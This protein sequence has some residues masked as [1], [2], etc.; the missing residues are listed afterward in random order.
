MDSDDIPLGPAHRFPREAMNCTFEV[1]VVHADADYARQAADAAFD[2]LPEIEGQ[3]SRF[4][5]DSDT[6]NINRLSAGEWTTVGPATWECLCLAIEMHRRTGGA[7]DVTLGTGIDQLVLAEAEHAV[8]VRAGGITVD[9]GGIGKGYA[10]DRMLAL[11]ADWLDAAVVHS[12]WS[13]VRSVRMAIDVQMRG[14]GGTLIHLVDAAFAGSGTRERGAHIIDPA[15]RQPPTGSRI[16]AWAVAP[17]AA[18]ADAL[19]TA[20]MVMTPAQIADCCATHEGTGGVIATAAGGDARCDRFGKC[21]GTRRPE[22]S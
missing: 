11:L 1:I 8:G 19:S 15:T 6:A 20:F 22:G 2:L 4:P 17:T 13:T 7:F 5:P 14:A 10:V 18:V 16:A 3:L 9:F 21:R 12:G